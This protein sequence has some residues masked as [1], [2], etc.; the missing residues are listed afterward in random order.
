MM[1]ITQEEQSMEITME[2]MADREETR[3]DPRDE[4]VRDPLK[5]L[6]EMRRS[7]EIILRKQEADTKTLMSL[8]KKLSESTRIQLK[9]LDSLKHHS[10]M[11][12][13]Q[14]KQ[15]VTVI[16]QLNQIQEVLGSMRD[17]NN[18]KTNGARYQKEAQHEDPL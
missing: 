12:N 17:S 7:N 1:L 8:Q 15:M 18:D 9:T 16:A 5:E 3:S 6:A 11:I 13:N 4:Q 10:K 14:S 2:G